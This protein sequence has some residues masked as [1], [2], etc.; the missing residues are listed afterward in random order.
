MERDFAFDLSKTSLLSGPF[1]RRGGGA[2]KNTRR[3]HKKHRVTK[4]FLA[5]KAAME[6]PPASQPQGPA[7]QDSRR[8]HARL[9]VCGIGLRA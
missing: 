6:S 9:R 3:M 1:P 2:Q 8:S 5:S 7:A 4:I